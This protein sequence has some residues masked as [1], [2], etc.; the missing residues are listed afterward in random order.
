MNVN[1]LKKIFDFKFIRFFIFYF[2]NKYKF[3]SF[4]FP[5]L[6]YRN[7]TIDNKKCISIGKNNTFAY[8]C[9]LSP[10]KL[11]IGNNN[12]IGVNNVLIGKILIGSNVMTGPNVLIAGA[13]HSYENLSKPMNK[14]KIIVKGIIIEDDVWI[15]GNSTI[16]DGIIIKKGSIIGAGSVV[17]KNVEEYSIVVGNPAK[18]IGNRRNEN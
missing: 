17:T 2:F 14:G 10:L 13:N 15:G 9:Y 3:I 5:N 11:S 18:E 4:G 16:L 7:V 6:M 8:N 12:W 1:I